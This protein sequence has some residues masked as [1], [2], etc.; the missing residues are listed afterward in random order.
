[1]QPILAV[2]LGEILWDVLPQTRLLGGAPAN[3]AYHLNALGGAGVPVSRV[4]DDNLGREAL[5][6]LVCLGLNIDAVSLDPDHPTGTVDARVDADGVATYVFPDD[7]AWDFLTLDQSAL[8]LA[9]NADAVCFGS[10]A[11]RAEVSRRAVHRFL[12]GA[13]KALKVFDINL[14]QDFY[15]PALLAASLDAA[16]VLKINDAE[17]DTVTRLFSLP[18]GEQPA[19][20]ALMER[21]GLELAVLTRGDKGSLLLSSDTVAD[22]PGEPVGVVDTIGAGDA[23]TAA[24]VLGYLKQW[25]L[26]KI[27]RYAAKVAAYVCTQPG[28]MPEV[29]DELRLA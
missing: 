6:L 27:N 21:H 10:L 11:Q 28:A 29:P 25:P 17:L 20:R 15:T 19:L 8:T 13:S 12:A 16:D 7:V 26:D 4:G 3:F 5:S 22:L 23:F 18:P 1:M 2:G 14:R 24:L 9:A